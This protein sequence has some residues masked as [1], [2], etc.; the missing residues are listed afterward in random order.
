MTTVQ[1]ICE[2]R[3]TNASKN[4]TGL[5]FDFDDNFSVPCK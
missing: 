5:W 3:N 1:I 2:L 4:R